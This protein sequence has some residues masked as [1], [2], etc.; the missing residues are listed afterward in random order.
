MSLLEHDVPSLRFSTITQIHGESTHYYQAK[1]EYT[2]RDDPEDWR[3]VIGDHLLFQFGVYDDPA[4]TQPISL[5]ES[6]IR[7]FD[8]QLKIAGLDQPDRR[9]IRRILDIGCGWGYILKHLAERFPEC[10]QL[11]GI[12]VS[13]RQLE[14]CAELHARHGLSGRIHLYQCNAKDI[15]LL[16][17]PECLYDLVVIRGAITHFPH[18]LYEQT[19]RKLFSRLQPGGQVIISESLYKQALDN[20]ESAIH[21]EVDRLACRYRKSPQYFRDV[22]EQLG[23]VVQDMRILPSNADVVHW[24]MDCRN[25]IEEHFS[26]GNIPLPFDEFRDVVDNLSLALIRNK[27]SVYSVIVGKRAA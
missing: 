22:L 26:N 17:Q 23:Y 18:E 15:D 6:G 16:P 1:V 24:M 4:S 20:Y 5:D 21:D 27:V 3:K 8:R 14:H 19:M 9:P 11:D 25:N 12:N 10:Q 2:Y 13:H 7:Y